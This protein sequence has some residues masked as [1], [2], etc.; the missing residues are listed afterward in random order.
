MLIDKLLAH[1]DDYQELPIDVN[2]IRERLIA[3]GIQDEITFHFVKMDDQKIRGI[4]Y[5]YTRRPGVYAEP[6]FCSDI[7]IAQD[8]GDE[9]ESWHRLVAV[10]ELLHMSDCS[11]LTAASEEAVDN[12]FT[13]FS[14]P[15]DV[16]VPEITEKKSVLN[17]RVRTYVALAILIPRACRDALRE[18]FPHR[19]TD[20]EIALMAGVPVRYIPMVM[21][22]PFESS[23][24]T[25]VSWESGETS[26]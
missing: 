9:T 8:Q 15:P 11:N 20:S 13:A 14:L 16:R 26:A 17:D 12:L 23:I 10:K 21:G 4:L 3:M 7:C 5:R 19:L 18:L 22:L 25:F 1:F 6:I 24:K 2:D